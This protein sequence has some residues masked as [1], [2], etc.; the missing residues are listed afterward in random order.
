[1]SYLRGPLTRS[2]IRSLTEESRRGEDGPADGRSG[3]GEGAG[4]EDPTNAAADTGSDTAPDGGPGGGFDRSGPRPVVAPDIAQAFLPLDDGEDS[5][6]LEYQPGLLG[7][8]TVHFTNRSRTREASEEPSLLLASLDGVGWK[9]AIE[10]SLDRPALPEAPA[11]PARFAS[12]DGA[13]PTA[14]ALREHEK[15]LAEHLYRTRTFRLYESPLL[16]EVSLPGESEGE[17]RVRLAETARERRDAEVETLRGRYRRKIETLEGRVS[18]AEDRVET[19]REQVSSSRL[20][21]AISMGTTLLSA[22]LG[23]QGLSSTTLSR[24]GSAAKGFSRS[25]KEAQD[26]ARAEAALGDLEAK[27]AGLEAELEAEIAA[28][29]ERY[30][31]LRERFETVELKPRRTDVDVERVALAWIPYRRQA[32]GSR[33]WLTRGL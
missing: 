28:M 11:G 10:L 15:A 26:V 9:D 22:V 21:T 18:R 24:A 6:N 5:G 25:S 19:E 33:R 16:G 13:S 17:F 12:F 8:A 4:V 32:D 7:L 30:D 20:D 23:R 29:E 31:P 1:M 3:A 27:L 2:Q 14:A